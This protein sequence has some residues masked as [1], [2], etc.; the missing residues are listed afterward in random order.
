MVLHRDGCPN[1]LQW[2]RDEVERQRLVEVDWAL[3]EKARYNTGLIFET[4]DRTGLLNDVTA[5]FSESKVF[6]LGIQTHSNRN[7]GTATLRIDFDAPSVASID[8]LIRRLQS[9]DDLLVVHRIGV[10]AEELAP[11]THSTGP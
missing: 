7:K 10:G 9:V 6:I 2:R 11:P 8:A 3:E 5:I 4:V 1:V